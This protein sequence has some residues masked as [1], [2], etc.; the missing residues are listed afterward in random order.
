MTEPAHAPA[1]QLCRW[2][3]PAGGAAAAPL[4]AGGASGAETWLIRHA[5]RAFVLKNFVGPG[6]RRH[7][8]WVHALMRHVRDA[9]VRQVPAVM[10][11]P[12]G[13]TLQAGADGRLWELLERM[14]GAATGA[15]TPA[16]VAAAAESLAR[17]HV[18][19]ALLPGESP[20]RD[21]SPGLRHRIERARDLLVRPWSAR[22]A[23][24]APPGL[25]ARLARAAAIFGAAGGAEAM[26]RLAASQFHSLALQPVLRDVWSDHVL[27]ADGAVTGL[28]DWH[29]AGIDTPATDIAR[30]LGSWPDEP[31]LERSFFDAY[32]SVRHLEIEELE[33]IPV[34]QSAGVV[35]G[36]DNWFRWM[37]EE[38]RS[39]ADRE[40]VMHR[41][42]VLLA[43]LPG[44]LQKLRGGWFEPRLTGKKPCG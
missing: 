5:G 6:G 23:S 1:E 15:P 11:A 18:A 12:D 39:F 27:F 19:A 20:R 9:G 22:D 43:A 41:I 30:L 29:A 25:G 14:P 4:A 44:A 34:L 17:V 13:A 3:F 33:L 31:L 40:K 42:D 38:R 16:Q 2:W 21:H 7:A 32:R 26:A 35:F 36:I 28:I 24:G 37:I 10:A 8:A